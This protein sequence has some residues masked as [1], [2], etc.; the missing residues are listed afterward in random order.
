M[1]TT[2]AIPHSNKDAPETPAPAAGERAD[3]G[4]RRHMVLYIVMAALVGMAAAWF[5]AYPFPSFLLYRTE[6]VDG[7]AVV[8]LLGPSEEARK[9]QADDLVAAGEAKFVIVPNEGVIFEAQVAR[10]F[11]TPK[12]TAAMSR[13]VQS[14]FQ[15]TYVEHTHIE[16]LQARDL[17]AHIDATRVI[18]VSAPYHMRRVKIMAG[19]IFGDENYQLAFVPTTYE[20]THEP[21]FT[22]WHDVKWVFSEWAKIVWFLVYAPFV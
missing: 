6:P 1:K 15:R 9:Q 13:A 5:F 21:W 10:I 17:I 8:L 19:R 22:S 7:G 12:K 4:R 18:F 2:A 16:I 11:V 14:E 20:T 3:A